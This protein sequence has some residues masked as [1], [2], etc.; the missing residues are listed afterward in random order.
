M[1]DLIAYCGMDC[2]RCKG[3]EATKKA[4]PE[5]R[6]AVAEEWSKLYGHPFR[7][8]DVNCLGCAPGGGPHLAYCGVCD[9]RKCAI[10]K[11]VQNCAR[12]DEYACA[13]LKKFHEKAPEPGER[14]EQ[15][16][17]R[18]GTRKIAR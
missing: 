4:D 17:K 7:P 8:E 2:G 18:I 3:L 16:R 9:I 15:I 13:P 11:K 14:L 10:R 5:M 12:C 6:R 1:A